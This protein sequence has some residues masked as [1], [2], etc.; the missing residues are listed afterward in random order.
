QITHYQIGKQLLCNTPLEQ[1]EN[2]I[3]DIVNH[4]Y[5]GINY[6]TQQLEKDEFA[7]LNFIAGKKA[8]TSTAYKAAIKYF[9][10]GLS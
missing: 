2:R 8:K 3:F 10:T 9:Q 6:I 7:Q 4:L 5:R 1:Q